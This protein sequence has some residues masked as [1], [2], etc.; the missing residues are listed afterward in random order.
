MRALPHAVVA[1][2][3]VGV[4][5]VAGAAVAVTVHNANVSRSFRFYGNTAED[6]IFLCRADITPVAG[7]EVSFHWWAANWTWLGV[8]YCGA[9]GSGGDSWV[10]W[11]QG[12]SLTYLANGTNGSSSFVAPGGSFMFGTLCEA[13]C[14]PL[15]TVA[16]NYTASVLV[17]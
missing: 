5:A 6:P 13:S 11:G 3:V 10:S 14:Q 8:W 9:G 2:I 7:T 1:G 17:L 4:V 15:A 16:G 12:A